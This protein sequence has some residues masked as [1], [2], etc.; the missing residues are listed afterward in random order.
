LEISLKECNE[1][2]YW[3]ELLCKTKKISE[4]VYKDLKQTAGSIRRILIASCKTAKENI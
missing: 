4:N 3:L 2:E 1:T